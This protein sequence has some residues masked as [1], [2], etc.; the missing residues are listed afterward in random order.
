ML[1]GKDFKDIKSVGDLYNS[2]ANPINTNP[3]RLN[4]EKFEQGRRLA[5]DSKPLRVLENMTGSALNFGDRPLEQAYYNDVLQQLMTSNK[6]AVA[7][8]EMK[9]T[10]KKVAQDMTFKADNAISRGALGIKNFPNMIARNLG[11]KPEA[12]KGISKA[13]YETAQSGVQSLIPFAKTPANIAKTMLEYSPAGIVEGVAKL[14]ANR[15]NIN[16]VKQ[17]EI[18]DVLTRGIVGTLGVGAGYAGSKAGIITGTREDNRRAANLQKQKGFQPNSLRVGDTYI[19]LKKFAPLS[20]PIIAGASLD[21]GNAKDSAKS[22]VDG[23]GG[24]INSYTEMSMLQG[25]AKAAELFN[26]TSNSDK[27]KIMVDLIMTLP[28][29]YVPSLLKKVTYINDDYERNTKS[30][31]LGKYALNQIASSLPGLSKTFPA[32]VDYKGNPIKTYGGNNSFG[33]VMF[34]PY[35]VTKDNKDPIL[36]ESLRLYGTTGET[37]TLLPDT[38]YIKDLGGVNLSEEQ[39]NTYQKFIGN[40]V[41][42]D[43]RSLL[44]SREY[45]ALKDDTQKA[46]VFSSVLS[47]AKEK[48]KNEMLKYLK[49]DTEKMKLEANEKANEKKAL[50]ASFKK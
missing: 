10:A 32:K 7:T 31:N 21:G 23:V 41:V 45:N 2:L 27:T 46:T 6:V 49:V 25:V 4:G 26:P 30:D 17:R 47:S 8:Q 22:Y 40:N 42:K 12:L 43:I 39:K 9:N 16:M 44:G 5:F 34:N 38:T 15:G 18:V 33:N 3:S 50:L 20:T 48:G 36:N 11:I 14:V 29:Q 24:A 28:K 19:D 1:G 13:G 35:K 37:E